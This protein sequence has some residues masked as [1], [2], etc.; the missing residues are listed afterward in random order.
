MTS[1]RRPNHLIH[2]ISFRP[3]HRGPTAAVP[4]Q[5]TMTDGVDA[6]MKAMQ[7][8]RR[9]PLQHNALTVAHLPQ[10]NHRDDPVLSLRKPRQ[11]LN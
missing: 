8:S 6:L 2:L 9:C 5:T 11:R 10:L 1:H 3:Q 7:P 4:S